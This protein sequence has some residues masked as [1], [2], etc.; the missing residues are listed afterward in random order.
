MALSGD[1]RRKLG[2][3]RGSAD[4]ADHARSGRRPAQGGDP[5]AEERLLLRDRSHQRQIALGQALCAGELGDR[6]R[7]ED[8]PADRG[9]RRALRQGTVPDDPVG[10]RR[11]CMDADVVRSAHPHRLY[12]VDAGAD[13][14]WRRSRFRAASRPLEHRDLVC[15][16]GAPP[17]Q[18]SGGA[19]QGAGVDVSRDVARVGCAQGPA[20]VEG[21]AW[22]PLE[23]RHARH[24]GQHRL[25]GQL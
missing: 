20:G 3:H 16:R 15:R 18:G 13:R 23:W 2:S 24:C 8:R 4:D 22:L 12:P 1:A 19:Q 6:L 17:A 21:R 11:A 9:A 14:L 7:P 5:G 10:H 25:P